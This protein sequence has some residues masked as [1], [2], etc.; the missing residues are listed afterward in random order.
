MRPLRHLLATLAVLVGLVLAGPAIVSV[1]VHH[2]L[3]DTARFTATVEPLAG[4]PGVQD[5]VAGAATRAVDS[6]LGGPAPGEPGSPAPVVN[7]A[8]EQLVTGR[9]F[10]AVW[11]AVTAAAHR[12]V[13]TQLRAGARP[14]AATIELAPVLAALPGLPAAA[15]ASPGV[16]SAVPSSVTVGLGPSAR[17]VADTLRRADLAAAWLPWLAGGLLA[18]AVAVSPW[19]RATSVV[20]GVGTAA[21]AAGVWF[22]AGAA[23]DAVGGRL[24]AGGDGPLVRAVTGAVIGPLRQHAVDV[25]VVALAVAAAAALWAVLARAVRSGRDRGRGRSGRADRPAAG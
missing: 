12:Q 3:L 22:A 9:R 20:A 11:T 15:L 16:L 2:D 5:A 21:V 10:P 8:A 7:T 19:W 14:A 4:Q 1:W 23:P 17:M 24:V 13:V 18:L 25:G 6:Y